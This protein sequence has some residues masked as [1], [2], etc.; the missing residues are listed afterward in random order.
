MSLQCP[1]CVETYTPRCSLQCPRVECMFACCI[2]CT[3]R[4][5]LGSSQEA[6]CMACKHAYSVEFFLSAFPK[7]WRLTEYKRHRETMALEREKAHL[8]GMMALVEQR[9]QVLNLRAQLADL[10]MQME[11][12]TQELR[13]AE[14]RRVSRHR[15]NNFKYK[16][17]SAGCCG[18]LNGE[19][20]CAMCDVSVCKD[21]F[22]PINKDK[23]DN[24]VCDKE[25]KKNVTFI[26]KSAKPCPA[27]GT[28]IH[29]ISGCSQIFC[30]S[31]DCGTAFNWETGEIE[32]GIIHNPHAHEWFRTHPGGR[33]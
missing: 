28:M 31:D 18:F 32:R 12:V 17:I 23:D 1:V 25:L 5:I 20:Y 24:H 11:A 15:I 29:K 8:P 22:A 13:T 4:Y 21:C 30:T 27:C 26:K 16:C 7:V 9:R 33:E 10:E 6:H 14:H 19:M 3:K 2:P